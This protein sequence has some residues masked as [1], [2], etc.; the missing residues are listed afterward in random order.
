MIITWHLEAD[1]TRRPEEQAMNR[2]GIAIGISV[3]ASLALMAFGVATASAYQT[4]VTCA[5]G[6]TQF[7]DAHCTTGGTGFGHVEIAEGTA[8]PF[9]Y[10]NERTAEETKSA[11]VWKQKWPVLGI[12]VS[13]ACT[14]VGANGSLTNKRN[15]AEE[16]FMGGTGTISFSGC[17]VTE[18]AGKGCVVTGTG[19]TTNT[20]AFT[21]EGQAANG[22][23]FAPKSGTTLWGVPI[24][25]CSGA[26][27][28]NTYPATGSFV[29]TA[30]GATLTAA[31]LAITTQNTLTSGGKPMGLEGALTVSKE[32]G[33][34]ISFT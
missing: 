1:K 3:L 2:R 17:T 12:S 33:N 22:V 15:A 10:T 11:A 7:S 29:L 31:H 27:F 6:G 20:L 5:P 28:N 26:G 24:S 14:T 21:T 30:S 25:G 9:T 32:G 16:M 19:F 4:A 34:P 23:K 13:V 8:T 18:P